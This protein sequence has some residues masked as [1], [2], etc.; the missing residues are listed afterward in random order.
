MFGRTSNHRDD[1]AMA[2]N[3]KGGIC[4]IFGKVKRG[5]IGHLEVEKYWEHAVYGIVWDF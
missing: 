1:L 2:M 3:Q 5:Q 4:G